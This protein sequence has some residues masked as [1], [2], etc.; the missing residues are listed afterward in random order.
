M[1]CPLFI[2][3]GLQVKWRQHHHFSVSGVLS[4]CPGREELWPLQ[5]QPRD[6]ERKEPWG[7]GELDPCLSSTQTWGLWAGH[8]T[9]VPLGLWSVKLDN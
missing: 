1:Y 5:L 3:V 8:F 6:S 7:L 4:S 2:F 9:S